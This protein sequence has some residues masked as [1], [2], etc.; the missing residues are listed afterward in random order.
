MT[1]H[2][3]VRSHKRSFAQ[4]GLICRDRSRD[5]CVSDV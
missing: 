5:W 3:S 2:S 1:Q 4:A